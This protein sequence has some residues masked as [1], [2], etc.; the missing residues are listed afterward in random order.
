MTETSGGEMLLTIFL[1]HRQSMNLSEINQKL[2]ET[3]FWKKFP[4]EGVEVISWYVLMGIGQVVTLK[5]PTEKPRE[6]NLAVEQNG[7]GAFETEFYA[8]YD[9]APIWQGLRARAQGRS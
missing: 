6:V 7:W 8:T 2:D 5:L 3:G 1:K 9:F 4:P